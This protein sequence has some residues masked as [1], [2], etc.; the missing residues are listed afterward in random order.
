MGQAG[1]ACCVGG[2][3]AC[4]CRVES[5]SECVV[6]TGFGVDWSGFEG[7]EGGIAAEFA[8]TRREANKLRRENARLLAH[9]ADIAAES[10]PLGPVLCS[11]CG[12]GVPVGVR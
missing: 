4:A 1:T 7:A 9:V 12:V 11:R 10:P 8:S 5:G 2:R 3:V 6:G